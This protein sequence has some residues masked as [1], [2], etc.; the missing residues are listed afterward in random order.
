MLTVYRRHR[1]DCN[2]HSDRYWR[3]CTCPVWVEG[4]GPKGYIRRSL[5]TN[6]WERAQSLSLKIDAG[7]DTAARGS[8]AIADAI[9]QFL[10]E[11]RTRGI[12]QSSMRKVAGHLR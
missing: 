3:R 9:E 2:K 10:A 7:E 4:V 11:A 8:I 12:T 1:K 5:K 6:S